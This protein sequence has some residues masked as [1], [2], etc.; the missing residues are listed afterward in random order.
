MLFH[1][2]IFGSRASSLC[3]YVILREWLAFHSACLS[4]HRTGIFTTLTSLVPR[5]FAAVS[6]PREVAAVSVPRETAA[7]SVPRETAAIS[8]PRETAA[9]SARS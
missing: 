3:S 4:I 2:A 7:V 6:V 1:S 9:V 8:V 5:E